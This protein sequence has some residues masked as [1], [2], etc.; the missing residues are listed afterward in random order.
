MNKLI[1]YELQ[2]LMELG[3]V[4]EHTKGLK[5]GNFPHTQDCKTSRRS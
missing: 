2:S 3:F 5:S 1:N 4:K